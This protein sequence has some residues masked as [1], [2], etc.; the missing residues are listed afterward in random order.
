MQTYSLI[1]RGR[2]EKILA[3]AAGLA[4]SI[5]RQKHDPAY[6]KH[7]FYKEKFMEMKQK[8]FQR[9]RAPALR[10]AK[11]KW[12]VSVGLRD[13]NRLSKVKNVKGYF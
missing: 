3:M 7:K 10:L 9:Y 1:K 13:K 12:Q 5:A 4:I 11:Q 8:I 2:R 6:E